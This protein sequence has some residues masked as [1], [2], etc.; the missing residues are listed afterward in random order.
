MKAGT[1]STKGRH[2][3]ERQ[4]LPGR[5]PSHLETL[6]VGGQVITACIGFD[7]A[8]N[9]PCEIFLN[10][11]KEGSQVDA[12]LADAATVISVA[13]QYGVPLNTLAK[14]VGR[15]PNTS[16]M[17]GQHRPAQRRQPARKPDRRGT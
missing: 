11:G 4:R 16:T 7:P 8:T 12:M 15:A 17:P 5:R 14:S 6:E 9:R 13:L 2:S 3:P 1:T 10:G